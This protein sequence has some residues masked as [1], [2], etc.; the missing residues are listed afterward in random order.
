MKPRYKHDH[1]CCT[2]VGMYKH[3]DI[4]Q[5]KE[6]MRGYAFR[7]SDEPEDYSSGNIELL[8]ELTELNLNSHVGN[9]GC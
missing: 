2:F 7:Y 6:Y 4:W 9:G 8:V 1:T 3:A 5:C